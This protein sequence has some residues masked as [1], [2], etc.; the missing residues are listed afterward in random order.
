MLCQS[1]NTVSSTVHYTNRT[2]A[3]TPQ[4]NNISITEVDHW[5]TDI[6]ARNRKT[7]TKFNLKNNIKLLCIIKIS[8]A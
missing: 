5:A 8:L 6:E 2:S 4:V 1:A 7:Q 3:L